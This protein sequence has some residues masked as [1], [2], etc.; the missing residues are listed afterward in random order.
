MYGEITDMNPLHVRRQLLI[1]ESELN[2]AE[3]CKEWQTMAGGVR[4]L[5][6]RAKALGSLAATFAVVVVG[7]TTLRRGKPG[8]ASNKLSWLSSAIK[9]ARL[10]LTAWLAFH[11]PSR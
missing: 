10:I 4:G 1:A 5:A 11:P 2:R 7:L 6:G 3:L 8:A 9:G